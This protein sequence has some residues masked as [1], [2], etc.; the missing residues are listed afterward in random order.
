MNDA[1]R[2][3]VTKD[4]DVIVIGSG[5]GGMAA[6]SALS[7]AGHKVLLLEKYETLAYFVIVYYNN[8]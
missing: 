7:Q 3:Q 5:M 2:D 8:P 4:W 6:A 1:K